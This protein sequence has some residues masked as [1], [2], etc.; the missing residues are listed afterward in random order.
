MKKMM[1]AWA[2]ACASASVSAQNVGPIEHVLVS[3]PVHKK[4]AETALPVTLLS[5]DDLRR[6]AAAS[7]GS[8]LANT[9]GLANASFG[10]G[11]G[12]PVIRGQSGPRVTVLQ[13]G[14][15]SADASSLSADHAVSVEP[16]LA[17]SIEV[18]RG[19][20]TLLYGGG[21]IGGIIN[22]I[23]NRIPTK[24]LDGV[25]GAAEWRHDTASSGNTAVARVEAGNGTLGWHADV[26]WRK[27]DNLEIPGAAMHEEYGEHEEHEHEHEH[28]H[29]GEHDHGDHDEHAAKGVLENSD[30]KTGALTLGAA[31]HFDAGFIGF[32]VNRLENKY[33]I[34]TGGHGH[35]DHGEHEEHGEHHEHE[36]HGEQEEH[37]HEHGP[38]RID[39]EQT[40][41][42]LVSHMHDPLPGIDVVRSFFTYTD[43]E[44]VE[45]EGQEVGTRYSNETWELRAEAVQTPRG[46]MHGSFGV[47][48]SGGEFSATG[49]EA[50]IPKTDSSTLG[51]FVLQDYHGERLSL[52]GGL[53]YDRVER[54]PVGTALATARFNSFS[55]SASAL[56]DMTQDWQFGV[57]LMRSERAPATEELF[58]NVAVSNPEHYIVHAATGAI[59]VGSTALDNEVSNNVDVSLNWG[60]DDFSSQ[61]SVFYNDFADY[62]YL[63]NTGAEVHE[64]PVRRYQ[65]RDAKFYGVEWTGRF[66]LANWDDKRVALELTADSIRGKLDGGGDVPRLPPRRVGAKLSWSDSHWLAFTRVL[67]AA[68][69]D[70]PGLNEEATEGYRRWDAGV[71]YRHSLSS[72][73]EL[74]LFANANNLTDEDIRLS[75]SSLREF[76]PEAGRSVEAGIRLML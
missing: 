10:P 60:I 69:Q 33:G 63:S 68:D 71:E 67:D 44:H 54:N 72:G 70:R 4:A 22:V 32:S 12:R 27:W 55:L 3:V 47:Q 23:D 62:I 43:Y 15:S 65:Q 39:L 34:P 8:T 48:A 66:T 6:Q 11:V 28:E 37:E 41:Y 52:E 46:N 5:G 25:E 26:L 13:N 30:G 18:L 53:R 20:A 35:G 51:I 59:E 75:T 76:A 7:I 57:A 74:V 42:D 36:G 17:D 1:M 40:R 31:W 19:P 38:V 49:E 58:S 21:A 56:Y 24:A 29:E 2:V 16:V 9:P 50:F 73:R 64:V 45:L 14:T 61:L